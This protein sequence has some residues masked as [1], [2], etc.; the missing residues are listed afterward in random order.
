MLVSTRN[1][2]FWQLQ[3][4]YFIFFQAESGK[5]ITIQISMVLQNFTNP[6][7]FNFSSIGKVKAQSSSYNFRV[8]AA[9]MIIF[10]NSNFLVD[11]YVNDAYYNVPLLV[12]IYQLQENIVVDIP[13][14]TIDVD[15]M[16]FSFSTHLGN[17]SKY[18]PFFL[19]LLFFIILISW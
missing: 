8:F 12:S 18:L 10:N 15:G 11:I 17:V 5:S 16:L 6:T 2:N 7:N 3:N 9:H 13:L 14:A 19:L 4:N 1:I